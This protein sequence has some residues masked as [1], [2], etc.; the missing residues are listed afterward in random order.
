MIN[1][2]K[3]LLATLILIAICFSCS[4]KQKNQPFSPDEERLVTAPQSFDITHVVTSP[5]EMVLGNEIIAVLDETKAGKIKILDY[6]GKLLREDGMAGRARNEFNQIISIDC[7]NNSAETVI[8]AYDASY[9]K[10]STLPLVDGGTFNK[11]WEDNKGYGYLSRLN[12]GDFI[13]SALFDSTSLY[14]LNKDGEVV[15]RNTNLPPNVGNMPLLSHSMASNG[16]VVAA[17]NNP[18]FAR[19]VFYDGGLDF[20]EVE[21]NQIIHKWRSSQFDM[22]YDIIEQYHNVPT[23]NQ[24]TRVGYSQITLSDNC[25]YGLFSGKKIL[26]DGINHSSDEIHVFDYNGEHLAR[27]KLDQNV[28]LIAVDEKGEKL[29]CLQTDDATGRNALLIYTL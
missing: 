19:C 11:E 14:L 12:N 8:G 29:Y 1:N 5:L 17:K 18:V 6:N 23:P 28:D 21:N 9:K 10:Y 22:D 13:A 15:C 25:I 20:F 3:T 16:L 27:L 2:T 7:F 4:D 26:G 24:N